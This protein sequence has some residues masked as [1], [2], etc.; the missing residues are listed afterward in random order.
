MKVILSA[1][2]DGDYDGVSGTT[3]VTR[4]DVDDLHSLAQVVGDFTRSCGYTCVNDVGFEKD[5][6]SMTFGGF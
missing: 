2:F 6:G 5:D 3:T 1:V 4:D